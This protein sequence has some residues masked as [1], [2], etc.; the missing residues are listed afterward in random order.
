MKK[1]IFQPFKTNIS[2]IFASGNVVHVHDLVD[3][4]SI[5]SRKAGK[6]AAQYIKNEIREGDY[7]KLVN[8]NGIVYTVPQKVR[9]E[10]IEKTLEIFMRV[11]KI[12]KDVILEV[13]SGEEVL[14]SKK[15]SH[16]APGEMERIL[17]PLKKLENLEEKE[18]KI[19][20]REE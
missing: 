6:A 15:K 4:V 18:I 20:I 19:E 10:N 8:G 1:T 16:M 7:I 17:V 3:F 5:E 14:I 12:F 9:R 13:K 11:N 2:G